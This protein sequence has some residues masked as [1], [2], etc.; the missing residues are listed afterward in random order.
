MTADP[1]PVTYGMEDLERAYDGPIPR[2]LMSRARRAEGTEVATAP[3]PLTPVDH[4]TGCEQ[5][6]ARARRRFAESVGAL[7]GGEA[8]KSILEIA[9]R[10]RRRALLAA[11]AG[12][13]LD[14]PTL[15]G[16]VPEME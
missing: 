11:L 2:G 10:R 4:L 5:R 8:A 16:I 7:P 13:D 6:L 14:R 1:M 9:C 3:R 12:D 15:L